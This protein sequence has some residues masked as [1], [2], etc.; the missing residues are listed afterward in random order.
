MLAQ[1]LAVQPDSAGIADAAE[2]QPFAIAFF[3]ALKTLFQPPGLE[4]LGSGDFIVAANV[5]IGNA[6]GAEQ[7]GLNAARH[8]GGDG[9]VPFAAQPLTCLTALDHFPTIIQ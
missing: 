8:K 3:G 6:A 7:G 1:L 4:A 2:D 5:G 9:I